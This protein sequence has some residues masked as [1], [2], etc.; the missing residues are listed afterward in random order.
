V[1]DRRAAGVPWIVLHSLR[2]TVRTVILILGLPCLALLVWAIATLER[3]KKRD[4][5]VFDNRLNAPAQIAID[6]E[7]VDT[8]EGQ[9]SVGSVA[10]VPIPEGASKIAVTSQGR[11]I[12]EAALAIRP[13]AD[14]E[15]GYRALYAIGPSP[16]Y[17]IARV[18]YYTD[19]PA[20]PEH[21]KL[22]IVGVA[23]PLVEL[24]R[25]LE[26]YEISSIDGSFLESESVPRGVA[27]VWRTRLCTVERSKKPVAIGCAG[28]AD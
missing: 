9:G 7:L 10:V 24:P 21:A 3:D 4:L 2:R 28:F 23:T 18:P 16:E 17:V 22:E 1:Q 12:S 27:M 26:S 20:S 14:G 25:E 8:V 5:V 15:H 19:T 11:A 13:R 6:G